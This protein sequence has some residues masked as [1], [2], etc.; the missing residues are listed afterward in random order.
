MRGGTYGTVARQIS[1]M[2]ARYGGSPCASHG[3]HRS[4]WRAAL[5][6]LSGHVRTVAAR[7]TKKM[8]L[9][10]L[11]GSLSNQVA[12]G[13]PRRKRPR[14][15]DVPAL[16]WLP[17][18]HTIAPSH[19]KQCRRWTGSW[20]TRR[21]PHPPSAPAL[22]RCRAQ[23]RRWSRSARPRATS[24]RARASLAAQSTRRRGTACVPQSAPQ[25]RGASPPALRL[26]RS[27]RCGRCRASSAPPCRVGTRQT[28]CPQAARRPCQRAASP[29]LGATR[30]AR[31]R[32]R[33]P[34]GTCHPHAAP[35][36]RT[37]RES[38]PCTPCPRRTPR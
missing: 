23:R 34:T 36:R 37:I 25:T 14:F 22:P 11:A 28:W 26:R 30:P 29:V 16:R 17:S 12:R 27:R 21:P 1:V 6:I 3:A 33:G 4:V 5:H 31:V 35:R 13:S 15:D 7:G 2:A 38:R 20:R 24:R 19:A 9:N 32:A 8:L 10:A 18:C